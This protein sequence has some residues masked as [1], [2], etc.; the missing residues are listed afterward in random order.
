V[1]ATTYEERDPVAER[2]AQN[3]AAF[4]DANEGIE[5]AADSIGID[6]LLPFICECADTRCT[7]LLRLTRKEYEDVRADPTQ[8]INAHGHEKSAQG[9]ARVLVA[10]PNYA[11]VVKIGDA[12]EIAVERDPRS[13][14]GYGRT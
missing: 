11:I 4:R 1:E 10:R 13:E 6:G 9:W 7:E 14:A 12:A 2:V 3:D 5:D 8:F